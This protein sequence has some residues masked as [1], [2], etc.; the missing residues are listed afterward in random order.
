MELVCARHRAA[1]PVPAM[2][3]LL[4]RCHRD[5]NRLLVPVAADKQ[6]RLVA[7]RRLAN[8]AAELLH[9]LHALAVVIEN[10]IP[11]LEAGLRGRTAIFHALHFHAPLFFEF[12]LLGALGVYFDHS[13]AE[14]ARG[15]DEDL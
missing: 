14:K 1:Q 10:D 15:R 7:H 4:P 9:S 12:E 8:E 11:S 2:Q 6:L 13:H 3:H 5:C